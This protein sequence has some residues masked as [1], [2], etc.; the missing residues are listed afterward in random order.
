MIKK[1]INVVRDFLM[2]QIKIESIENHLLHL[3][4]AK[5]ANELLGIAF[6]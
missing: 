2:A 1:K 4:N 3:N 5:N 6:L